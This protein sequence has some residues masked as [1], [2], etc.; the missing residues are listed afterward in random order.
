MAALFGEPLSSVDNNRTDKVLTRTAK[1]Y[2][3]SFGKEVISDESV[4]MEF[5]ILFER[6]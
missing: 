3:K 2:E 5:R 6:F 4:E 1:I